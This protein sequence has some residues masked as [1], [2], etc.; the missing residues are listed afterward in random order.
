MQRWRWPRP[1]RDE[2]WISGTA[3]GIADEVG[4]QPAVIRIAFVV[5]AAAG[6]WGLVLYAAAWA[7]MAVIE[8]RDPAGAQPRQAKA[9]TPA[10]RLAGVILITVGLVMAVVPLTSSTLALAVWPVGVLASGMLIAWT[11]ADDGGAA[12]V[13][14]VLAITSVSS[15]LDPTSGH[16]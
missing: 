5:L 9:A 15:V 13:I 11:R 10:H 12:S 8:R 14:R 3:A 7:T 1:N 16:G 4:V 2:R 6:G